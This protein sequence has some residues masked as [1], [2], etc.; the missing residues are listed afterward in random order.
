MFHSATSLKDLFKWTEEMK[1]AFKD[2]K[3]KLAALL[4]LI[5]LDFDS[6]FVVESPSSQW[7]HESCLLGRKRMERHT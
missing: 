5:I 7:H 3:K 2:L 6:L 1:E 4:A